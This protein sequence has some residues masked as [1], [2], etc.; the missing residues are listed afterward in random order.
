MKNIAYHIFYSSAFGYHIVRLAY[1]LRNFFK[2]KCYLPDKLAIKSQFKKSHGYRLNFNNPITL[3]EKI[4]WLKLHDRTRLHVTY[5]DKYAARK[6][7]EKKYGT[8][9]L[10]ELA[11]YTKSWEDIRIENMPNYPFIIKPNHGSGWFKIVHDKNIADWDKIRT[12]CRFWLS[13]NYYHVQKEWHYKHMDRCLIVEKLL[14]C[15]DGRIPTNFR[16]HC[17]HG[18]VVLIALT[19]YNSNNPNDYKNLKYSRDWEMLPIDWAKKDVDLTNLRAKVGIPQPSSLSKMIE[20][21]EDI[22]KE[23]KYVRVDFYDVDG[24]VYHGEITFF[25][26]GG[27][28][29]IS[30]YEWDIKLGELLRLN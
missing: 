4:Q 18:K 7:F 24:K 1:D 3:N 15:K 6:I 20:L 19:L 26:G 17:I 2:Y 10:I 13:Q 29:C 8:D 23:F 28:E 12:D 16:V 30:P 25:D 11:F 21:A 27:Y 5:A 9:A 22:S 14:I